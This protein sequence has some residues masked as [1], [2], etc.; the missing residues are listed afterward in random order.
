[1][2]IAPVDG[3]FSL[4]S[5]FV[6]AH[7]ESDLSQATCGVPIGRRMV[8]AMYLIRPSQSTFHNL[9]SKLR[10][11]RSSKGVW[12]KVAEQ[13]LLACHFLSPR[14][15]RKPHSRHRHGIKGERAPRPSRWAD[16]QLTTMPQEKGAGMTAPQNLTARAITNSTDDAI[17]LPC[18]YL[19]NVN[20]PY[21]P[22]RAIIAQLPPP[23]PADCT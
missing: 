22:G 23:F 8:G 19:F 20:H 1:M 16:I 9:I 17:V 21:A 5:R 12:L 6:A 18:G 3:L 13:L 10:K 11:F 4:A 7:H 14:P 15:A 2:V